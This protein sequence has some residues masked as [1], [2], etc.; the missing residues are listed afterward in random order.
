MDYKEALE[1]GQARARRA[2][3]AIEKWTGAKACAVCA[4]KPAG[5]AGEEGPAEWEPVG[6]NS[7]K[8]VA[9]DEG[10]TG[11]GGYH[12]LVVDEDGVP[13]AST[14]DRF[15]LPMVIALAEG[16]P[17]PVADPGHG[18]LWRLMGQAEERRTARHWALHM[19]A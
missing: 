19:E 4:V 3:E 11:A 7:W 16:L 13:K 18:E 8:E 15:A 1:I 6:E 17:M 2:A 14:V 12:L 9:C 10:F 5:D